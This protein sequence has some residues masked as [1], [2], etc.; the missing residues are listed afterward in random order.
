VNRIG[1]LFWPSVVLISFAA[2]FFPSTFS[3]EKAPRH[4][5]PEIPAV[6]LATFF[7]EEL[8]LAPKF[9]RSGLSE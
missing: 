1:R 7:P 5:D 8:C 6:M 2:A 9:D 4:P 3:T